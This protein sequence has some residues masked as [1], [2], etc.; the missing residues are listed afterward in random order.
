ND[1]VMTLAKYNQIEMGM[2]YEE[3][4]NIVGSNGSILSESDIAGYHTFM[5]MWYGKGMTGANANIIIQNDKVMTKSQI[6]LS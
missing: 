3:V 1:G 5:V 2:S 6:G 4:C